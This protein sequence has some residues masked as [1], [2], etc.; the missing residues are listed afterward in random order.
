VRSTTFWVIDAAISRWPELDE[1]LIAL[2]CEL[3]PDAVPPIVIGPALNP[4]PA[5]PSLDD[6]C[7]FR[8]GEPRLRLPRDGRCH[9]TERPAVLGDIGQLLGLRDV[10]C[11]PAER[12]PRPVDHRDARVLAGCERHAVEELPEAHPLRVPRLR[13]G[14]ERTDGWLLEAEVGRGGWSHVDLAG[15]LEGLRAGLFLQRVEDQRR[16]EDPLRRVLPG[17]GNEIRGAFPVGP[18]E[19]VRKE[20]RLEDVLR[21]EIRRPEGKFANGAHAEPVRDSCSGRADAVQD[22]DR[23]VLEVADAI[24][25]ERRIDDVRRRQSEPCNNVRRVP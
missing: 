19:A 21:G 7:V 17:L 9:L 16:V 5:P 14:Q 12:S 6:A 20:H 10:F 3:A 13:E 23:L 22:P 8:F 18:V 24:G 4:M 15:R 11:L 25:N 1:K 2:L